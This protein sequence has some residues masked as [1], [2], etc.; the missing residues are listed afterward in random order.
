MSLE[1]NGKVVAILAEQSGQGKNGTWVKQEFVIETEEQFPK[2]ACF[3]AWGDKAAE[4]K[5]LKVGDPVSV[6]FNIESREFNNKWY[7][8]LR[9]WKISKT[10]TTSSKNISEE[11]P[12]ITENDIPMDEVGDDLP[13]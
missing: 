8:D 5:K 12:P 7:T 4:V 6:G 3:S 13:F 2:K 1:I 11:L 9:A 10:S